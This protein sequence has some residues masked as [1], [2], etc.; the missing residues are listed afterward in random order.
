VACMFP[1]KMNSVD[2]LT[3]SESARTLLT[4]SREGDCAGV[5]HGRNQGNLIRRLE[6]ALSRVCITSVGWRFRAT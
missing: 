3:R 5:H 1:E 4:G 6:C 2:P